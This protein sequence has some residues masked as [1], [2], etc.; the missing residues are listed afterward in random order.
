MAWTDPRTWVTSEVVTAA[1]MN[2]HVRDNEDFL[3]AHHG[4]RLYKS[5]DQTI[6][7]GNEDVISLNSESYDTDTFHSTVTNNS[8]VIAPWDGYYKVVFEANV[9][10]DSSHHNGSFLMSL[11]LNAAG[12]SVGGSQLES[13]RYSGH[14]TGQGGI[15]HWQ[16]FL[17]A[18]QY[19]EAFMLSA[20]EARDVLGGAT[21]TNV[22]VQFM[23]G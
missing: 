15:I 9:N 17:T 22:E 18:G 3:Y 20:T 10:A 7:S 13:L 16:G 1:L 19:V 4:C 11:R 21:G 2:T 14:A 12:S 23:G 5:A 6:A 8:R